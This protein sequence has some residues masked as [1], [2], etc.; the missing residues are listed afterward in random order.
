[1]ASSW[2][3]DWITLQTGWSQTSFKGW[4]NWRSG[5][6]VSIHIVLQ[7]AT[8]GDAWWYS[9][10]HV[11]MGAWTD[12]GGSGSFDMGPQGNGQP[13]TVN[14]EF[15]I[16]INCGYSAGGTYVRYNASQDGSSSADA[17]YVTWDA[18]C[19][20]PAAP[21][22]GTNVR[23]SDAQNTISW[24]NNASGT[25][26]YSALLVERQDDGGSWVQIAQCAPNTTSYVDTSTSTNHAYAYRIRTSN[27]VGY[28]AYSA[29]SGV[30]YNTPAPP[31]NLVAKV[32]TGTTI[33]LTWTN[34]ANTATAAVIERSINNGSTWTVLAT[35]SGSAVS[36][37]TDTFGGTCLYR[38]KLTGHD[39]ASAYA[40]SN[41]VTSLCAPAAPTLLS[42]V[43][44]G[45]V[46]MGT[47]STPLT[48]QHN[49]IDTS[50]Q[51][52]AKVMVST[53]GGTTW[54]TYTTT[55]AQSYALATASMSTGTAVSWKVSTKGAASDYGPWSSIRS[56]VIKQAPSLAVSSPATDGVSVAT[57]PVT[58]SFA[59]ADAAGSLAE[60]SFS[61]LDAT[62]KSVYDYRGTSPSVTIPLSAWTPDN[63][64]SYRI[65]ATARS[66]SS[67]AI[68]T[69]RTFTVAYVSPNAPT[70]QIAVDEETGS[71]STNVSSGDTASSTAT[72]AYL[73]IARIVG[74]VAT[75][76][77]T[78][79]K[80][81]GSITDRLPPLNTDMVYR[82][83]A[84]TSYG[85]NSFRDYHVR[86]DTARA[87]WNYGSGWSLTSSFK[88]EPSWSGDFTDDAETFVAAG[89]S[90]PI[91]GTGTLL[92]NQYKAEGTVRGLEDI[93][94]FEAILEHRLAPMWYRSPYGEVAKV[95]ATFSTSAGSGPYAR[96]FS[97]SMTEV[98]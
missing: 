87:I 46:A 83:Y 35:V 82:V 32:L 44:S 94:A 64:S 68:S 96:K 5:S 65:E 62:G 97:I 84:W 78:A 70:A 88:S 60:L 90:K 53:D 7:S 10:H 15:D 89:H 30:T 75:I 48:W 17:V 71:V 27:P 63:G 1:M 36:S 28:S 14:N 72:T 74:G 61:V 12:A 54:T 38:V 56:F 92:D 18:T 76:I 86:V 42:P 47:A 66:S 16:V 58:V 34:A 3:N 55:T 11:S 59:Y 23:N 91:L 45:V 85:A 49:S 31:T 39:L 98:E 6:Q 81:G 52:A 50:A 67:L 9:S 51:T 8:V 43:S 25:G 69:V 80:T 33:G 57:A 41:S 29:A 77:A 95:H 22:I 73:A 93:H 2:N 4:T 13:T 40:T 24:T 79:M 21:T 37:Y 26:Y 20:T 19:T